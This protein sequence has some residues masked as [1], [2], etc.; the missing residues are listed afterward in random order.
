[1][2]KN[3]TNHP[4]ITFTIRPEILF[5]LLTAFTIL[6]LQTPRFAD[7]DPS[8]VVIGF[9]ATAVLVGLG[10]VAYT[11]VISLKAMASWVWPGP[12]DK[13]HQ[14]SL[15]SLPRAWAYLGI[16]FAAGLANRFPLIPSGDGEG[17]DWA[18]SLFDFGFS[19]AIYALLILGVGAIVLKFLPRI[20]QSI[21]ELWKRS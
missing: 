18:E 11:A 12:I 13:R 6:A 16:F 10:I 15:I 8:A 2:D 9:V 5:N 1:M 17:L 7:G 3:L 19:L 20:C 21:G 14:P 4:G